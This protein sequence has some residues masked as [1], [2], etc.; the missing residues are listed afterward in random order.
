ML[1]ISL[2]TKFHQTVHI[3]LPNT[4]A[5]FSTV[6]PIWNYPKLTR[7]VFKQSKNQ[8]ENW[9]RKEEEIK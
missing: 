7:F 6:L 9:K 8:T 1:Q 5:Y 2:F 4:L 3:E